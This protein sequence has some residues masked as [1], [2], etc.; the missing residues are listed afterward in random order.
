M[1]TGRVIKS[2]EKTALKCFSFLF[3]G[4]YGVLLPFLPLFFNAKGLRPGQISL[5]LAIGPLVSVATQPLWGYLSDRK[6]TVKK[7]IIIQLLAVISLGAVIFNHPNYFLL[8]AS[9][10]LFYFFMSPVMP[11]LDSLFLSTIKVTGESYGRYRMWGSLGFAT[12]S[13]T[14]GYGLTKLGMN[15][16]SLFFSLVTAA[17]LV[18]SF[19]VPES[20]PVG[21]SVSFGKF[22]AALKNRELFIFLFLAAVI[23]ATNFVNDGFLGIYIRQLGGSEAK[24]GWA[25]ALT[26]LSAAP[27]LL[28]TGPLLAR[29]H[30]LALLSAASFFYVLRWGF[31]GLAADPTVLVY[32]QVL[33]SFTYPIFYVSSVSYVSR[34]L[35]IEM[36]ATAQTL[37]ATFISGIAGVAGYLAGGALISSFGPRVMYFSSTAMCLAA[38]VAFIFL[39][40]NYLR[41][42]F[43]NNAGDKPR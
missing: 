36:Q 9:M 41:R 37:L 17:A 10:F 15:H 35:P 28:L 33:N 5:L 32:L 31:F 43:S 34:L 11:L 26:A 3:Y 4:I 42:T 23:S 22:K 38:F 21:R 39:Y 25:W 13:L 12:V 20:P 2:K 30:E 1:F 40:R 19:F 14:A 24:V 7:L 16:I 18:F 29:F 8:T 27:V 6:N